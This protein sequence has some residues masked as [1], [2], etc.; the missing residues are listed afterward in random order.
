MEGV[1]FIFGWGYVVWWGGGG[2][3]WG[4][5]GWV[6]RL[7]VSIV[8]CDG[9]GYV[10]IVGLLWFVMGGCLDGGWLVGGGLGWGYC[11]G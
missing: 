1:G 2:G 11:A 4:F 5:W 3:G 8:G 10:V 9:G 6:L 7:G